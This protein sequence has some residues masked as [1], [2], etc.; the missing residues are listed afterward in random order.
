MGYDR[1]GPTARRWLGHPSY[2]GEYWSGDHAVQPVFWSPNRIEFELAPGQVLHIN[3]NPGSWWLVNGKRVFEDRRCAEWEEEFIVTPD[4]RG[5]L[6]LQ[7]EPKA[8][9]QA[10]A[11]SGAG[12]LVLACS[13]SAIVL[14]RFRPSM[15][16]RS[17]VTRA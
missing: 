8:L 3:Q 12:L 10:I 5:R 9:R 16:S 15:V 1:S 11:L 7:V 6:E 4:E 17:R 14:V 2:V 13:S